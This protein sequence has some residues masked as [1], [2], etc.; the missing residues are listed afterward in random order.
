MTTTK[1]MSRTDAWVLARLLCGQPTKP[2][3]DAAPLDGSDAIRRLTDTMR[4]KDPDSRMLVWDG[5]LAGQ[6]VPEIWIKAVESVD[7]CAPPPVEPDGAE[8]NGHVSCATLGDLRRMVADTSWPWPGWLAGGVLN[9]L[10]ADPGVGKTILAMNLA[11]V[12]W[13]GRDWPDSGS[14]PFPAGTRTLWVPG[15]R[16]YTQ[17]LDLAARYGL[18]DDALLFNAPADKPVDGLD[19]DDPEVLD[20]LYRRIKAQSPGL[21]IVDTVGMTTDRNLGRPEEARAY[22][23]PLMTMAG[24]TGVPFLLLTHLSRDAQALGRRIVG[25]SRVVWKLTW[26]DPDGQPHRR[27]LWVD[28]SYTI[29][30]DAMGMTIGEQGCTFDDE[31][32]TNGTNGT[33][34]VGRPPI[35]IEE[36]KRWLTERLSQGPVPLK[37]LVDAAK[38]RGY[39]ISLLYAAQKALGITACTRNG[40]RCW[41]LSQAGDP[42]ETPQGP[43]PWLFP[44]S[45]IPEP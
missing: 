2:H 13:H 45:E 1:M 17:L 27:K 44:D 9:S 8:S 20:A 21:V 7:P 39:G 34:K 3:E 25:A 42:I 31:P 6:A 32:P 12:L 19:L 30:P 23:G 16:H 11:R 33:A 5:F 36:C 40:R 14:N 43:E 41:M 4:T 10:A 35:R 18:A 15:D 28:K 37:E 26:P 22:F 29:I 24:D 38:A